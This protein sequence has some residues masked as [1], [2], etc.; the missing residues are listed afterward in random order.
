MLDCISSGAAGSWQMTNNAPRIIADDFA[1]GF[2]IKHYIK[3]MK[4]AK[5]VNDTN[6][7]DLEVLNTVLQQFEQLQTDGFENL[8]TQALIKYYQR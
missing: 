4:I 5:A 2:Y 8:G 1:P 6:N 7:L 3:D